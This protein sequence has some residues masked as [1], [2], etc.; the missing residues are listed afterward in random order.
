MDVVYHKLIKKDL[1]AAL[2][3]Y[4][5]EGG[6]KLGDRFF[7]DVEAT[8]AKVIGNPRVSFRRSAFKKSSLGIISLSFSLRG[9][10]EHDLFS[11]PPP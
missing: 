4:D 3:Y 7:Q 10:S 5:S 2:G 6:R 11:R 9:E 1:R 8:I